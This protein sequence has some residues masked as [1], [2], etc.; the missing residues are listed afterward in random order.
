MIQKYDQGMNKMTKIQSY[1]LWH[2]KYGQYMNNIIKVQIMWPNF[3]Y[4]DLNQSMNNEISINN[5]T[6]TCT[7]W[8]RYKKCY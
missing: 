8:S 5:V 7:M 2:E 3:E 4:F 1:W 6:Y